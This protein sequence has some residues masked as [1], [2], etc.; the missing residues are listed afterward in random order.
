M[1]LHTQTQDR[2][3]KQFL[4]PLG[5]SESLHD[6]C[7]R[8]SGGWA[9]RETIPREKSGRVRLEVQGNGA[10]TMEKGNPAWGEAVRIGVEAG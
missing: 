6:E 9:K 5:S 1:L 2:T 3:A 8:A 7:C 10:Q 4:G